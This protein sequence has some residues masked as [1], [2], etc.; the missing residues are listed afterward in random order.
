[1]G[2][3]LLLLGNILR[4]GRRH[5]KRIMILLVSYRM[6]S[7]REKSTNSNS[8]RAF[9]YKPKTLKRLPTKGTTRENSKVASLRRSLINR[10]KAINILKS[11]IIGV[12]SQLNNNR[13]RQ[14]GFNIRARIPPTVNAMKTSLFALLMTILP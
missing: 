12:R 6:E 13:R 7:L 2:I 8:C 9:K 4:P 14:W 3:T 10:L 1:M 5:A 11:K